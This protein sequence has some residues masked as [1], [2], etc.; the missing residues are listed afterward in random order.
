MSL[1]L[2]E[3][4]LDNAAEAT[5]LVDKVIKAL[6]AVGLA[7]FL[8]EL[9]QE[10]ERLLEQVESDLRGRRELLRR[11][12]KEGG[13]KPQVF[14]DYDRVGCF[15]VSYKQERVTVKLGTERLAAFV[16]A[17]GRALFRRLRGLLTQLEEYPFNRAS[18]FGS[19]KDA[20]AMGRALGE[21]REGKVPVR[22]LHPLVVLCRQRR[23]SRF[24]KEPSSRRFSDYPITQ[25]AYDLARFGQ[26]G[27][28]EGNERL[29]NLPPNI[30]S[31]PENSQI[32]SIG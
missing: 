8:I 3:L 21:A 32:D 23:D 6:E 12:A 27:W 31:V 19:V 29:V 1:G 15:R 25:F 11:E 30:T 20:I 9:R 22:T 24:L 16:E 26:E 10:R 28:S 18:F 14:A 5:A 4:K 7:E 13:W 2:K 17:D